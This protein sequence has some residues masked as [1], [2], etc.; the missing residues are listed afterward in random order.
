MVQT[1]IICHGGGHRPSGASGPKV[2]PFP[3]FPE[4][5]QTSLGHHHRSSKRAR[6]P[7]SGPSKTLTPRP[8]GWTGPLYV[9]VFV[10]AFNLR[11]AG[12]DGATSGSRDLGFFFESR[13]PRGPSPPTLRVEVVFPVVALKQ[14]SQDPEKV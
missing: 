10:S 14:K 6:P 13:G 9:G 2:G 3:P 1:P 8:E 7:P 11:G 4:L 12:E 5:F